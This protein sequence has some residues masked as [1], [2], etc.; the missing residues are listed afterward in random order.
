MLYIFL[1]VSYYLITLSY[2]SNDSCFFIIKSDVAI[3][4]IKIQISITYLSTL[5]NKLNKAVS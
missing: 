5:M 2:S 1:K 3:L 4:L